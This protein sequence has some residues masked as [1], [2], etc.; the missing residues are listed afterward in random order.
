MNQNEKKSSRGCGKIALGCGIATLV[1]IILVVIGGWFVARNARSWASSGFAAIINQAVEQST[2]PDDQKQAITA[3]VD[4]VKQDFADG[5]ITLEQIGSAMEAVNIEGLIV[6]G[7]A[8]N[9]GASMVESSSLSDDDKADAKQAL[10]RLAHG[11]LDGQINQSQAK[12]ALDPILVNSGSADWQFKPSPTES[13][14]LKVTDNA[15]ALADQAGVSEEAEEIDFAQRVGEA[16]DQ[17]LGQP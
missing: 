2:L 7:M 10:N 8:Q 3:R 4:Q 15:A 6:A 12:Q 17:A 13:D 16:F 11:V 14:L 9:V 1:I 5:K